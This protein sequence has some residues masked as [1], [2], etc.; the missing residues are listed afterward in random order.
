MTNILVLED[1]IDIRKVI[2]DYLTKQG[3]KLYEAETASEAVRIIKS[4]NI[5]LLITDVML[6]K[7]DGFQFTK[8]LRG[9]NLELPILMI[10][11]KDTIDDKEEGFNSGVDDY[12][13]KPLIL[14]ELLLRVNALLK[15]SKIC[16]NNKLIIGNTI[17]NLDEYSVKVDDINIELTKKE[18][19]LLYKL[20]SNINKIFTKEIL[21]DSIWGF[22]SNSCDTTIKV[23]ISKIRDKIHSNDFEIVT[24]K[25][26]G[27]K[28]VLK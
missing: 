26:L 11:A 22:D 19:E 9:E 2:T 21:M 12:M 3:F 16:S 15:R 18:F 6:P 17:L 10:T 24:V 1:D 14:K 13:I 23:H 27:Y 7:K 25:G 28:G 5:E 20:L 4:T 8:E